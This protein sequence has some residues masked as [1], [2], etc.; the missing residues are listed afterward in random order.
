MEERLAVEEVTVDFVSGDSVVR[1]LDRMSFGVEPGSLS[2]LLGPSGSGKTTLLSVLGGLL[3][4]TTGV[5]RLGNLEVTQMG[6][7][8]LDSYRR[9]SV[10]FVFQA[11]NLISS[12]SARENIATPLLL[13][14]TGRREALDRAE[15][16]ID[17]VGLTGHG[18]KRPGRL[19]GGQQQ[20]VA[21]ARAL[22]NDP[23]LMLADEPTANLDHVQTQAVVELL[24]GL[25]DEGRVIVVSSH[26]ARVLPIADDIIRMQQS[27]EPVESTSQPVRYEAAEAIFERGDW[28]E[29]I[30]V[31]DEGTVELVRREAGRE[32]TVLATLGPGQYFG[33][34]GPIFGVSRRVS[35]RAGTDVVLRAHTVGEFR[36]MTAPR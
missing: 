19:S 16:L 7:S 25:R 26:D 17:A 18:G 33:E 8:Q 4:P 20:R 9:R 6:A 22:V 3:R 28:G 5:V 23:P 24:G 32:H 12:L 30:Y 29:H 11:F 14:G 21:I 34:L 10:G 35:A 15:L 1:A 2:V 36:S 31:I 13:A 27:V